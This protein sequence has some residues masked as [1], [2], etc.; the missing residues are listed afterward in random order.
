M[1]VVKGATRRRPL[2]DQGYVL[3]VHST[4]MFL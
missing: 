3:F 1:T 2:D 4:P